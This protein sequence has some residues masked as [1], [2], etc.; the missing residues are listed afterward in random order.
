MMMMMMMVAVVVVVR[1]HELQQPHN[2]HDNAFTSRAPGKHL[3]C[4]YS[5]GALF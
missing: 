1:T 4:S 2:S 3:A 5:C